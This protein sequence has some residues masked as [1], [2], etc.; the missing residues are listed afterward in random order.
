MSEAPSGTDGAAMRPERWQRIKEIFDRAAGLSGDERSAYLDR[1]CAGDGEL[2]AEVESLLV[3]DETTESVLD[4]RM[5]DVFGALLERD[6]RRALAGREIGNYRLLREL[7]HGGMAVVYAAARADDQ[8][9]KEVA[10]KLIKRGMDSEPIIARFLQERQIL[11]NLDHPNIARLFDG[12]VTDDGSPYLVMELIEGEPID[13]YCD[14]HGLSIRQRL[15]LFLTV[16]QAVRY[17]H[18]NLIVH[19]DLKP[20]NILVTAGGVPKLLDFGIAKLLD[21]GDDQVGATV[22]GQRP[23]TPE[24]ASPEQI[25]GQ[26][27]TTATDVY[28]LGV[29]LYRLL[30]GERPYRLDQPTQRQIERAVCEQQPE[31]PSTVVARG[32]PSPQAD[33]AR[34]GL[35]R[36]RPRSPERL[37]RVLR[38]DLDNIVLMALEKSPE[39]RYASVEQLAEDVRRYLDG[40]PV[41]ARKDTPLY[42][43]SKFVRRHRVG[44]AAAALIVA[45]LLGGIVATTW[46]MQVAT[47]E[48]ARAEEQAQLANEQRATAEQ[49][50]DFLVGLFEVADPG[51][52]LGETITARELLERGA[53][54]IEPEL[55][56]RPLV[57]ARIMDAVGQVYA[58]LG[59]YD[60]ARPQLEGA[61]EIR[62]RLLGEDHLEVAESLSVLAEVE[63]EEGHLEEAERLHRQALE[64]RRSHFGGMH[65]LVAR[66]QAELGRVLL[67]RGEIDRA[68]ALL[69][70]TLAW[71]RQTGG[72]EAD[73]LVMTLNNL[74]LVYETRTRFAEAEGL[75]RQALAIHG[76]SLPE[77]HPE[78]IR[79]RKNL[80]DV[81][82]AQGKYDEARASYER[83]LDA[84]R[85]VLGEN[86]PS[87][88]T[89]LNNFA[90]CLKE[91]HELAQAEA[92]YR[93][94][95]AIRQASLP[96]GHELV[97]ESL[98]N[99]ANVLYARGGDLEE[100]EN[101]MRQALER[102][103]AIYGRHPS[104][105]GVINNL[106]A[107]LQRKGDLAAAQALYE[108]ALAINREIFGDH[109]LSVA[110]NLNNLGSLASR[111]R[112]YAEAEAS[113]RQ[114]LP[115]YRQ[116]LG[117]DHPEVAR[118]RMNLGEALLAL[119][120]FAEAESELRL[121]LD[122]FRQQRG[123]G[124]REEAI[125][126]T[127]LGRS[128]L[129]QGRAAEAETM[130]RRAEST[131]L[132]QQ[133]VSRLGLAI[134][135][136]HLG[137][138]LALQGRDGEAEPLLRDS[139]AS[140]AGDFPG[141]PETA[142]ALRRLIA[143]YEERGAN[144]EAAAAR[145]QL[146]GG[147]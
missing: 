3:S 134:A 141:R 85:Q 99:L 112:R 93:R 42:R 100:T 20:S 146:A 74:A 92:L 72:G 9:R 16:C 61:L 60:D 128:L 94:A 31:R 110:K 27:I 125:L 84:E 45:S 56:G 32:V 14:R 79:L 130:L 26:P 18:Q 101:L 135:R 41:T 105:A 50:V 23:M 28:S 102:L 46:Q 52:A 82:C 81:L 89:T 59:L 144:A 44:V 8:Y 13:R 96:P 140:L 36:R 108:E 119:G 19:R 107:V 5:A 40:Q 116:L 11:A 86:N 43:A 2:R 139:A 55:A 91:Q 76:R 137:Q 129:G 17:A 6:A 145:A 147:G 48:R 121:A 123:S 68:E 12:G 22:A 10:I 97:A 7:G 75:Y 64:I 77:A 87:F 78:M 51:E 122:L 67:D 29:L 104:V 95:L 142:A 15:E 65:P 120:R 24:Y 80:A 98:N 39:R 58:N 131:W 133:P 127:L 103:R 63:R 90:R 88:A 73:E 62:R 117:D 83:I 115:L 49:V 132:A 25:R 1:A 69:E 113:F 21:P 33:P 35:A 118:V 114:A 30:T 57:Q 126:T 70:R 111:R 143:F 66:S 71:Q 53:R 37:R 138:A 106:A 109:H 34:D 47:R 38:G 124:Q 136:S 54:K 4:E